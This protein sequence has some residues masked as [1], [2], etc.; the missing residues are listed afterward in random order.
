MNKYSKSLIF[1]HKGMVFPR[2]HQ[3]PPHE[4]ISIA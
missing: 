3:V 1:T 4:D 2:F